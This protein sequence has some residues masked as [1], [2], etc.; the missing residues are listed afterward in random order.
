MYGS[1]SAL[2]PELKTTT[3]TIVLWTKAVII[4]SYRKSN[5]EI[6]MGNP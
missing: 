4:T 3:G 6:T 5:Y 1:G 2:L